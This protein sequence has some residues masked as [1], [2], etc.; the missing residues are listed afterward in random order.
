MIDFGRVGIGHTQ[1]RRSTA[2]GRDAEQAAG[3]KTLDNH[4]VLIPGTAPERK[5]KA[6]SKGMHTKLAWLLAFA[7]R[8]KLLILDEPSPGGSTSFVPDSSPLALYSTP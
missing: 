1:G 3:V 7:R 8:P 2:R 4:I 6:L 5:V